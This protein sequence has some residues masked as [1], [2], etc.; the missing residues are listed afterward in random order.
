M[1]HLLFNNVA[2]VDDGATSYSTPELLPKGQIGVF[3]VDSGSNLD[4]TGANATAKMI[5][6]QGVA[7]GRTPMKTHMLE[8]SL[9]E[10]VVTKTY[11]APT[12]QITY[13]GFNGTDGTIENGIGDY[14]LKAIDLTNGYEPY[15]RYHANYHNQ[16]ADAFSFVIAKG[17]AK[18]AGVN[19]RFFVDAELVS[20]LTTA[21]PVTAST[22]SVVKGSDQA[23]LSDET[24]FS[25]GDYIRIGSADGLEFP[26]YQIKALAGAEITLDRVYKGDTNATEVVGVAAAA[27][28]VD[29]LAGI[30]LIGAIPAP[31]NIEG[32]EKE[33]DNKVTTFRTALSEDFGDTLVRAGQEP[34]HGSGSYAQLKY[35]EEN[36]QASEGYFYRMTPFKAE[37]P[38]FFA[39]PALTYDLVTIL[40]RTNTT[41]NIAKSNKYVEIVLAFKAGELATATANLGTFF[42]V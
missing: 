32:I 20:D 12:K 23:V 39:D 1:K 35:A 4:L 30:K 24:S 41:P 11:E 9:I 31:D 13:V 7:A 26:V 19:E 3:D 33:T 17:L 18:N 29:T 14:L 34:N 8:K 37:K 15:P 21:A 2:T 5:I 28:D 6:A 36:A 27:P 16:N 40:Y 22:I 10:K 25:E 42:G 38:E